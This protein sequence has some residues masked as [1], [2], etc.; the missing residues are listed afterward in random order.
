MGYLIGEAKE[1]NKPDPTWKKWKAKNSLIM[2]W[3]INSMEPNIGKPYLFLSTAR[4]VWEDVRDCY[5]DLEN[6]SQIC[7][8][9]THLWQSKQGDRDVTTYYNLMLTLWQELD[10][11]YEEDWENRQGCGPIQEK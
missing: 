4:K 3:M 1:P 6:C 7:H 2:S 11:F 9:K 8:L 10:K 5:S